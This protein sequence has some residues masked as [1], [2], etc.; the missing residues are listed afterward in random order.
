MLLSR[1]ANR[2]VAPLIGVV[3]ENYDI[4]SEYRVL[5]PSELGILGD[6]ILNSFKNKWDR[7]QSIVDLEYDI[8]ANVN[9]HYIEAT[10]DESS[11]AREALNKGAQTRGENFTSKSSSRNDSSVGSINKNSVS[12]NRDISYDTRNSELEKTQ[13]GNTDSSTETLTSDKDLLSKKEGEGNEVELSKETSQLGSK[14]DSVSLSSNHDSQ[15]TSNYSTR[16]KDGSSQNK[17]LQSRDALE[18]TA[19][20]NST[21]SDGGGYTEEVQRLSKGDSSGTSDVS[22]YGYNSTTGIPYDSTGTDSKDLKSEIEKKKVSG[23]KTD[24]TDS[25]SSKSNLDLTSGESSSSSSEKESSGNQLKD[26][27][28]SEKSD[29]SSKNASENKEAASSTQKNNKSLGLESTSEK[30]KNSKILSGTASSEEER[31]KETIIKGK[32]VQSS[33]LVGGSNSASTSTNTSASENKQDNIYTTT[34]NNALSD[35]LKKLTNRFNSYTKRGI[36]TTNLTPQ[37]FISKEIEL[38]RWNFIDEVMKDII[39]LLTS[40]TYN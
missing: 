2:S 39:S 7:Y 24:T 32:D 16:S 8:I 17:D 37:D 9:L 40:G 28:R 36:D 4:W 18:K 21:S 23:V 27:K 5:T 11:S 30:A 13:S 25:K 12:S 10:S 19:V 33:S 38:W 26:E 6:I 3:Q 35:L 31:G 15:N 20:D 29:I 34:S 1:A 22:K 14:D